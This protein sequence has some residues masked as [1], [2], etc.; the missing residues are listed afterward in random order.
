VVGQ[1]DEFIDGKVVERIAVLGK[2]SLE[3][4]NVRDFC[5]LLDD[6][7]EGSGHCD[8][9]RNRRRGPLK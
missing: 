8:D 7:V 1:R 5:N 6:I 9:G 2:V 3:E 4:M